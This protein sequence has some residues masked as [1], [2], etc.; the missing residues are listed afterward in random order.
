MNGF[1]KVWKT[2]SRKSGA[3]MFSSVVSIDTPVG[4]AFQ[5]TAQNDDS[6]PWFIMITEVDADTLPEV[7]WFNPRTNQLITEAD[8]AGLDVAQSPST[9]V[10]GESSAVASD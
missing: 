7:M 5:G 6:R 2:L 1:I 8:Y 4:R 10:D 3:P 9:S